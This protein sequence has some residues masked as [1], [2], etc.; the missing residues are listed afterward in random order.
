MHMSTRNELITNC[1]KPSHWKETEPLHCDHFVKK[2]SH[3][4][5]RE[6]M[7]LQMFEEGCISKREGWGTTFFS[8]HKRFNGRL[9]IDTANGGRFGHSIW[10]VVAM[11]WGR[12]EP[13]MGAVGVGNGGGGSR[14]WGRWESASQR[15]RVRC[16]C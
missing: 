5:K 10:A 1:L 7:I 13:A 3:A 14:Q 9:R 16:R 2:N 4:E 8:L 12:W 11:A 15:Y 6:K